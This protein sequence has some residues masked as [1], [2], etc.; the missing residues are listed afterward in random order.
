MSG[1]TEKWRTARLGD[2]LAEPLANGRSVPTADVGFPVL[3]LTALSGGRINLA[4]RK[5]GAWTAEEARNV[6]VRPGDI[7]VSRGNGSLRLVGL[8]GLV[9]TV[10]EPVAFPDTLIRVRPNPEV[11]DPR[12]FVAAW[13]G[14][15]SR[16]QIERAARTTAGIFKVSQGDLA[17]IELPAP[18]LADQ[19]RIVAKLEA[20]Q[21]ISGR[22]RGALEAVPPLLEKL[23][24][25]ILAAA[26]RG[27]L[28]KEWRAKHPDVEPAS[29]LLKRIRVERR[30]KWEEVELA[31]LTAKGKAPT[32]DRW[33]A[34]YKEPAPVNAPGLPELPPGW[35]WASLAEVT[36][37]IA[38]GTHQPPPTVDAGVP[39][40]GIRNIVR[41]EV[42]WNTVDK[43]VSL[44]THRALTAACPPEPGD[45]LYTAVG[46]TFGRAVELRS[47]DPFVFQR[48][49]ALFRLLRS[50]VLPQYVQKLLNSPQVFAQAVAS[51]RG[52]AQPTVT[53]GELAQ[54][55]LPI[56]PIAEQEVL[57]QR[58][59]EVLGRATLLNRLH[60]DASRRCTKLDQ[61]LLSFAFRGQ[62]FARTGE[63]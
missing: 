13:N 10:D 58:A 43:W 23:R 31:K 1:A 30:K 52:A 34:K 38:D 44:E 35:C 20:L 54:F 62:L 57:V 8:A 16:R 6:Q 19:Q 51:A 40:I 12:F 9:E 2:V 5:T 26:F 3:R 55:S 42:A 37:R 49:I 61:A 33:K 56:A 25:S 14:P 50:I 4:E 7:F 32:D 36:T 63:S 18:P 29:E 45:I 41:D 39:F 53:L 24:Q 17:D 48:H 46:A 47:S 27:D 21:S 11:F 22:A 59:S 60:E 28:T 15:D